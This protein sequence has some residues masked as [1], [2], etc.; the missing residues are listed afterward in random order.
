MLI[1]PNGS[2]VTQ[3][4]KESKNF[5]DEEWKDKILVI[6]DSSDIGRR[7]LNGIPFEVILNE[8]KVIDINLLNL[9]SS[10]SEPTIED[11]LVDLDFRLSMAEL[12][13]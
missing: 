10:T 13:L 9:P 3:N 4:D 11:Y 5:A 1:Y 6:D 8:E 12:G 2:F 7:I